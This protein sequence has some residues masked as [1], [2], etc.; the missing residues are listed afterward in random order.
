MTNQKIP[1][2]WDNL[3]LELE[4]MLKDHFR[5]VSRQE[6]Q[7]IINYLTKRVDSLQSY[8]DVLNDIDL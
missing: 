4:N 5:K 8:V 1:A 6:R 3:L 2:T 7:R